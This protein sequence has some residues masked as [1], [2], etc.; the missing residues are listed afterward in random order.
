M[1]SASFFAPTLNRNAALAS[2]LHL[3]TG[4][5]SEGWALAR[6]AAWRA[7]PDVGAG[8]MSAKPVF[9][10][11]PHAGHGRDQ[12]AAWPACGN[13]AKMALASWCARSSVPDRFVVVVAEKKS[14]TWARITIA[15]AAS[16]SSSYFHDQC[17][18]FIQMFFV[19]HA[20]NL[21][22]D[23][24]VLVAQHI[25]IQCLNLLARAH[26]VSAKLRLDAMLRSCVKQRILTAW[27]SC[28]QP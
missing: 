22:L 10:A 15:M 25:D 12:A 3:G 20:V 1:S 4:I 5:G 6:Q 23:G 19:G 18:D 14:S 17:R 16:S 8:R 7:R 13:L 11:A 9:V 28:D 2:K 21:L 24:G 27:P 26:G